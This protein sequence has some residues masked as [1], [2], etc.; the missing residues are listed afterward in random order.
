M[1]TKN[2]INKGLLKRVR[3]T[4]TGRVKMHRAGNRHLRSHKSAN[5]IR[6]YR[7]T[8]LASKPDMMKL[9]RML[10]LKK[11]KL[12]FAERTAEAGDP[13]SCEEPTASSAT[14]MKSRGPAPPVGSVIADH[15]YPDPSPAEER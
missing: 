1:K 12:R 10:L 15:E 2:K 6:G 8:D 3:V 7:L 13:A 11:T 9:R 4:G 5:A 14:R